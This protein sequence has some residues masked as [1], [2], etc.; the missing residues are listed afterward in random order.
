MRVDGDQVSLFHPLVRSAVYG[1]ATSGQRRAAHRALADVLPG[2]PDRRAW[3]LAAAADRADA[4]TAAALDDVA[5][6]ATGRAGH[7]AAAARGPA[8]PS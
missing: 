1:A 6:R 7:E 4:Q 8:R 5:K 2:D 3:H